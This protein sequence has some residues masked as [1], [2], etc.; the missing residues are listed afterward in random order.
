M[1]R[2]EPLP[3]RLVAGLLGAAAQSLSTFPTLTYDP[4]YTTWSACRKA[5]P[6]VG[7]IRLRSFSF[8]GTEIGSSAIALHSGRFSGSATATF[9]ELSDC[10]TTR[11]TSFEPS[12]V[13]LYTR[14]KTFMF[15]LFMSSSPFTPFLKLLTTSVYTLSAQPRTGLLLIVARL[16]AAVYRRPYLLFSP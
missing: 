4:L 1:P 12:A 10:S 14:T 5:R 11:P 7:N 8:R 16:E 15:R 2:Q 6:C 3:R 9:R 13:V